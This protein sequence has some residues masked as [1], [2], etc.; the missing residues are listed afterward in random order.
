MGDL[1]PP[2]RV[3]GR[4]LQLDLTP[5]EI[6]R[7]VNFLGYGRI[8]APVWFI[9]MEEGLG[10]MSSE[11]AVRS[12]KARGSFE[13][14]MDLYQA[15]LNLRQG[16]QPIDIETNPPSTP[17]WK[18]MAKIM[19]AI[20]GEQ[21]WRHPA[22]AKEYVQFRLGRC[23]G[24]SF[25]TE[26]S[27][28]PTRQAADQTWMAWFEE[29][30][31]ELHEKIGQRRTT[32]KRLRDENASTLVI[33]YGSS[34]AEKFAE[35]LG[36]EWQTAFTIRHKTRVEEVRASR[37]FKNWLLPFFGTGH[38]SDEVIDRL[39]ERIAPLWQVGPA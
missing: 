5:E 34:L 16:G 9:G 27:P 38:M 15:C 1:G 35:L 3:E 13:P 25:L 18:F 36:I 17:V 4:E 12:L 6:Q 7:I 11:D 2:V 30:D 29:R 21:N 26:L 23:G 20:H 39:L 22:L 14:T 28:I 31:A 33:C 8:T 32:L 10:R 19:R 24:D 37:D